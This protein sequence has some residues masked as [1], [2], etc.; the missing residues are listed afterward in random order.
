MITAWSRIEHWLAVNAPTLAN[1]LLPGA[2]D[3]DFKAAE[4]ALGKTLPDEFKALYRAHNGQRGMADGVFGEWRF[5]PLKTSLS[6]WTMMKEL[7]DEG[8]FKENTVSVKGPIRATWWNVQW[9]PFG[10]NGSGNF[11][12]VDLDPPKHGSV[13]QVVTYLHDADKREC[14]AAG[15]GAWLESLAADLEEGK[16]EYRDEE[17]VRVR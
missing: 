7:T 12:V 3:A 5:L 10:S 2:T 14:V 9:V 15:I 1:D 17:L 16:L 11:L 13:G 4:K 8:T 6:K